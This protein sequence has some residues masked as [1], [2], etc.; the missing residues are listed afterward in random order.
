MSKFAQSIADGSM[1]LISVCYNE[2][3]NDGLW[4]PT[5]NGRCAGPVGKTKFSKIELD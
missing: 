4:E 2:L 1:P 5:K 3:T